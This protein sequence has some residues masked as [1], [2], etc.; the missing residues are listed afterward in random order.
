VTQIGDRAFRACKSLTS[1][2]I[3]AFVPKIG[4]NVVEGCSSLTNWG[5]LFI[6][7]RGKRRD[8]MVMTPPSKR[9]KKLK[10]VETDCIEYQARKK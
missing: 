10:H 6:K 3:P 7:K 5:A 1:L 8:L 2:T 9:R 4:R